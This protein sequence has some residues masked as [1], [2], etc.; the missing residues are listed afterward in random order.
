MSGGE[1]SG[2]GSGGG[3]MGS[4]GGPAGPNPADKA[5]QDAMY[6]DREPKKI[7]R[8]ITVSAYMVSVSFVGIVLSVYYIFLWHPPNPRLMHAQ[9]ISAHSEAL[10]ADD[11]SLMGAAAR[12][13]AARPEVHTLS[14]LDSSSVD[15]VDGGGNDQSLKIRREIVRNV[16]AMMRA[17]F[18]RSRE[19]QQQE[20]ERLAEA[21]LLPTANANVVAL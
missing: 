15:V 9:A 18:E 1:T 16:N 13:A 4:L 11:D 7:I 20:E 2:D 3:T 21:M 17:N 14:L 10:R 5:K 12:I 19:S 8:I 6:E